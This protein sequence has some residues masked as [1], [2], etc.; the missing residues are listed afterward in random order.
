MGL[1]ISRYLARLQKIR[2]VIEAEIFGL[3]FQHV[4]RSSS[5]GR[6]LNSGFILVRW[7]QVGGKS[8]WGQRMSKEER[9]KAFVDEGVGA[10]GE[11]GEGLAA[12]TPTA[13]VRRMARLARK[14]GEGNLPFI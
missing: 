11:R 5:L 1:L 7:L 3:N 10:K 6:R 2:S 4:G 14:Q 9:F 8:G 12:T 13:V